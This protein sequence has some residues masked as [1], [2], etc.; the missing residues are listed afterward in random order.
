MV[1]WVIPCCEAVVAVSMRKSL[2]ELCSGEI[3]DFVSI[4]QRWW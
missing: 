1:C 3:P 2:L 4:W